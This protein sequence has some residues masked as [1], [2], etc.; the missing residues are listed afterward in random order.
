MTA[1]TIYENFLGSMWCP[2]AQLHDNNTTLRSTTEN[3][4]SARAFIGLVVAMGA[5]VYMVLAAV[6]VARDRKA[7]RTS[8]PFRKDT[9]SELQSTGS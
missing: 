8:L 4:A 7:A 9:E 6:S 3:I 2:N 5:F 1:P